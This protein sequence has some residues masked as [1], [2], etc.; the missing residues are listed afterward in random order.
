MTHHDTDP[1]AT[2]PAHICLY[3][4]TQADPDVLHGLSVQ[5]GELAGEMEVASDAVYCYQI[6]Q[7]MGI[8]AEA[9]WYAKE[10]TT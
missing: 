10:R 3:N 1:D 4:L 2:I 6:S 5:Y 8:L 7:A 9:A